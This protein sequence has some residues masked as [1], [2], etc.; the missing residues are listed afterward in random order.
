M[1]TRMVCLVHFTR[2]PPVVPN[3]RH[4]LGT[5]KS[6]LFCPVR[7]GSPRRLSSASASPL[8]VRRSS[9]SPSQRHDAT[10]HLPDRRPQ[11]RWRRALCPD[12]SNIPPGLGLISGVPGGR[13]RSRQVGGKCL[14]MTTLNPEVAR[15]QSVDVRAHF[16]FDSR[17]LQT[18]RLDLAKSVHR[19][20]EGAKVDLTLCAAL[21]LASQ[22]LA[23]C[24]IWFRRRVSKMSPRRGRF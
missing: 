2:S 11:R 4:L 20:S 18:A 21:R 10:K 9:H 19:S 12:A 7:A 5:S 17:R 6:G 13:Q 24:S 15:H 8:S 22:F 23:L 1:V 16:G 3:Q 14:E